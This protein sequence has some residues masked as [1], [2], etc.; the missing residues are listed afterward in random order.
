MLALDVVSGSYV[1]SDSLPVTALT[2]QLTA[3][4][5]QMSI[6]WRSA[7]MHHNDGPIAKDLYIT[8]TCAVIKYLLCYAVFFQGF[9]HLAEPARVLFTG[10]T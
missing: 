6:F 3:G 7:C 2:C 9:G 4:S 10:Q 8:Y 1:H 5:L